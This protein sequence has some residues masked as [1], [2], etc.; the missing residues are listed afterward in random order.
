MPVQTPEIVGYMNTIIQSVRVLP[1]CVVYVGGIRL[2][3][4]IP[5]ES[6]ENFQ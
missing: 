1:G 5:T 4:G 6:E 2:S 3:A